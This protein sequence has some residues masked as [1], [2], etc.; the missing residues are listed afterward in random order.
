M[1]KLILL[2]TAILMLAGCGNLSSSNDALDPCFSLSDFY[3]STDTTNAE[4]FADALNERGYIIN[5]EVSTSYAHLNASDV[6]NITPKG[7]K[8]Y[9]SDLD[10]FAT[11]GHHTFILYKDIVYRFSLKHDSNI[12]LW[13]Y[14]KNGILDIV[15]YSTGGSCFLFSMITM[16]DMKNMSSFIAFRKD[17]TEYGLEK[18]QNNEDPNYPFEYK[19]GI[20]YINGQKLVYEDGKFSL[21][22]LMEPTEP[23]Y[24]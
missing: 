5:G 7:I 10:V 23:I 11:G 20:I 8:K 1:K 19:N 6:R 17:I 2:S 15:N 3:T 13:D 12:M 9:Y 18:M 14:D 16:F 4:K 24:D 22:S 21:G